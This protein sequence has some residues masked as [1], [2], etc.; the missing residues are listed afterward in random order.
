MRRIGLAVAIPFSFA[1]TT[2]AGEAQPKAP[3]RTI[4]IL[5]GTPEASRIFEQG[6]R[7]LGWIEGQ[8][9]RFERHISTDYKGLLRLAAELTRIPV[10]V[11][12][13]GNA[14]STRAAMEAT[15]TIPIISVSGDPVSAGFVASLARPG[16]NVTGPAIM[17]TE[18]SGKRL[19]I[20][21]QAFPAAR[22]I[23]LLAN[24]ANPATPA[25][26][27]ET[28]ARARAIGVQLLPFEASVPEQL[29]D[30]LAAAAQKRPDALVVL[31]DPMFNFNRRRLVEATA[32]HRLPAVYEWREFVEA[33][34]LMAYGPIFADLFR[35]A[36][37]YV[38]KVLRGARLSDLPVEQASKFELVINMKTKKALG[39]TIPQTLLLRADQVIE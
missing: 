30:V 35:S 5:A 24:P 21:T 11:I 3:G 4:G 8:N 39:L 2:L 13:A 37:T 9:V 31:S 12:L 34:G 20:L 10:D 18:L 14:P 23:A 32:Q 1:L 38:D 29:A 36:A 16:A 26:R 17:N 6:L 22:R 7:D 28:E 15:K 33:G 19:E 25:M 27:R